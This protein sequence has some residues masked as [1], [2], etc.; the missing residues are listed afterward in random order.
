D[1][2]RAEIG[3]PK[4]LLTGYTYNDSFLHINAPKLLLKTGLQQALPIQLFLPILLEVDDGEPFLDVE[5]LV[6]AFGSLPM[7]KRPFS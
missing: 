7:E 3:K 2:T 5:D 4:T 6:D 1:R